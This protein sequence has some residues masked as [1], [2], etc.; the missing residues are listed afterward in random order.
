[1]TLN[2]CPCGKPPTRTE[3]STGLVRISCVT[4]ACHELICARPEVADREWNERNPRG[5]EPT[6]PTN[7]KPD[8]SEAG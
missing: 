1:M 6:R 5:D 2:P 8:W 7:A 4:G 3:T